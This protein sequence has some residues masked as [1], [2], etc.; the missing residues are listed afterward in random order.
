MTHLECL[1]DRFWSL[2]DNLGV[3]EPVASAALSGPFEQLLTLPCQLIQIFVL[4]CDGKRSKW[5][6]VNVHLRTHTHT[7]HTP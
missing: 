2:L 5:L 6:L 7:L 1:R 4:E 3:H